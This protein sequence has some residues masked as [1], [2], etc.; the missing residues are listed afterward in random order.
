MP[1]NKVQNR[2]QVESALLPGNPV[3]REQMY[4]S[5]STLGLEHR[6]Q[7]LE[8]GPEGPIFFGF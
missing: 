8:A 5:K 2:A 6:A 1:E 7:D 3:A 4:P